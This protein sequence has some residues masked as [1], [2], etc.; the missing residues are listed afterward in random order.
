VFLAFFERSWESSVGAE[1][2]RRWGR[3]EEK[4]DNREQAP[5]FVYLWCCRRTTHFGS[6]PSSVLG[7]P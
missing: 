1:W 4:G 6:R 7:P 5:L 2:E 3:E